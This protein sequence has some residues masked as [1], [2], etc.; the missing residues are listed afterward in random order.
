V[1]SR[2]LVMDVRA[3][4]ESRLAY[5]KQFTAGHLVEFVEGRRPRFAWRGDGSDTRRF[6]NL[7]EM[8][9][10]KIVD[11]TPRMRR[12]TLSGP[13]L[14]RYVSG[15]HHVKLFI[16]P[17]G[18]EKPEWPV[19]GEDGIAIWPADTMRPVVRTYTARSVDLAANTVDIDFVLHGDHSIGSR[20]AMNAMP[21]DLVG[22]RGPAGRP[23]PQADWYLLVG[24]ETALPA[25]ARTLES[26]PS[27]TRGVA[28]IEVANEAEK[29]PIDHPTEIDVRWLFRDGAEAGT[30]DLLVDAVRDI[31]MPP[32]DMLI[33]AMA[34]IEYTAFKAIRRYWVDELALDRK[35]VL[36][37]A[38]WRRGL[39]EGEPNPENDD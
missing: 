13:G 19:P 8:T 11:V 1:Q 15:G 22:M 32:R 17:E 29:Q 37:V 24:D 31:Q 38:Y 39:T 7:H 28:L 26:L 18:I 2:R 30:T 4:D 16:P 5:M 36:A 34:G 10:T 6:P 21:G 27:G 23:V 12:V 33:H 20:W 14:E 25:I 9:I 35:D 3:D